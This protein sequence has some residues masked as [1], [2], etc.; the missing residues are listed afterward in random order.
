MVPWSKVFRVSLK[1]TFVGMARLA[2][3]AERAVM[4]V[5]VARR[6]RRV[7]AEI[8]A[9]LVAGLALQRSVEAVEG[10]P[11]PALV[12]E[13]FRVEVQKVA[14]DAGVLDVAGRAVV[15]GRVAMDAFAGLDALGDGLVAGEALGGRDLPARLMAALALIE[16]LE[17]RVGFGELAWG[18]EASKALRP[19]GR[20]EGEG[21][22][23][24][25]EPENA[26]AHR[27]SAYPLHPRS[28]SGPGPSPERGSFGRTAGT[29][30][31][32]FGFSAYSNVVF[33]LAQEGLVP[34]E[35]LSES[36]TPGE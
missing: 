9:R 7:Q 24:R 13:A 4:D 36:E 27:R 6:A 8:R 34:E 21:G 20:R 18:D 22:H 23:D 3:R 33:P 10:E 26:L 35:D 29:P 16:A 2:G 14:V 30:A 5:L 12:I 32:R 25:G 19:R 15:P 1:A 31:G 11:G 28:A 17:L